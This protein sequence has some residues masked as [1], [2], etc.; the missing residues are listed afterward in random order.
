MPFHTLHLHPFHQVNQQ[1]PSLYLLQ[2]FVV[3]VFSE[4]FEDSEVEKAVGVQLAAVLGVP[5]VVLAAEVATPEVALPSLQGLEHWDMDKVHFR[6]PVALRIEGNRT[7]ELVLPGFPGQ[8]TWS[9]E[10]FE[11]GP[12]PVVALPSAAQGALGQL[13]FVADEV[14][15]EVLL[16]DWHLMLLIMLLL[17][18]HWSSY[19]LQGLLDLL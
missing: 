4:D 11:L 12:T 1:H 5:E 13:E 2:R 9:L 16:S 17:L 19:L 3:V 6:T 18:L 15:V 10:D 14:G 7:P 8:Y